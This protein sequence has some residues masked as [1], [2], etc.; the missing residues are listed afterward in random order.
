MNMLVQQYQSHVLGPSEG[1]DYASIIKQ[2][3][4]PDVIG[5]DTLIGFKVRCRDTQAHTMNPADRLRYLDSNLGLLR[6]KGCIIRES[7]PNIPNG[8]YI[9][10]LPVISS[11]LATT[12]NNLFDVLATFAQYFGIVIDGMFE[13]SVSGHCPVSM[14]EA[15]FSKLT[16]PT[17][18][19]PR[20]IM[21]NNVLCPIGVIQRINNEFMCFRTRWRM[22]PTAPTEQHFDDLLIISQ[23]ISSMYNI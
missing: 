4:P 20:I 12:L 15:C 2:S 3:Y 14:V 1:V 5:R 17:K 7:E 11:Q 10:T 8:F 18:Y 21:T 23:L 16:I 6:G 13:I 19:K 22:N 9:M